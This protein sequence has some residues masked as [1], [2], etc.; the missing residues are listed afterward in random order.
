MD[1]PDFRKKRRGRLL[2]NL[3]ENLDSIGINKN[4][5][6]FVSDA[7]GLKE[8]YNT[9]SGVYQYGK[10]LYIAGTRDKQD[11]WDD[12]TKIPF[13][14]NSTDIARY[15]TAAEYIK[16]HPEITQLTGHSLGGAVALELQKQLNEIHGT[17]TFGAPVYSSNYETK[18]ND[19]YRNKND[20]VSAFDKAAHTYE[21]YSVPLDY[22]SPEALYKSIDHNHSYKQIA[23]EFG[24]RDNTVPEQLSR[25]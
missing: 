4:N 5:Y 18:E 7:D 9:K 3:K 23:D 8:A 11:V 17:R 15:K 12:I 14:G 19:R 21:K 24:G 20:P 10:R 25:S 13:W 6:K 16:E 22:S 1:E 2:N